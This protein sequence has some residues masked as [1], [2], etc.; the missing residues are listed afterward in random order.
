MPYGD[1]SFPP[2]R[3]RQHLQGRCIVSTIFFTINILNDIMRSMLP[4][5]EIL[6]QAV[7]TVR[8]IEILQFAYML[9]FMARK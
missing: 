5:E 3:T 4:G 6:Y 8:N 7:N 9:H 1:L 2:N